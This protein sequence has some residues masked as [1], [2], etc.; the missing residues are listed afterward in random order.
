M[1]FILFLRVQLFSERVTKEVQSKAQSPC[2][3]QTPQAPLSQLSSQ[4]VGAAGTPAAEP[5]ALGK[6]TSPCPAHE[7]HS[8]DTGQSLGKP[9]WPERVNVYASR[10]MRAWLL[11]DRH[12]VVQGELDAGELPDGGRDTSK[13]EAGTAGQAAAHGV[14]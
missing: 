13:H 5:Q 3:D 9:S 7:V 14:K 4:L 6:P 2:H 1:Y 8:V 11:R 10:L 12:P